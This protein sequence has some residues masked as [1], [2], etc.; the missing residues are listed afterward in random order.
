MQTHPPRSEGRPLV[1]WS[2]TFTNHFHPEVGQ[3]AVTV[4]EFLGY[5]VIVP[6]QTCCGRPLYDF[7]LLDSA[8]EHLEDVFATLADIKE[9]R[10]GAPIDGKERRQGVPVDG[11]ERRQGVPVDGKERRQGVPVDRVATDLPIV[12]L[13]PSCFS[14]FHDEARALTSD[15]PI[16]RMLAR[17]AVLFDT[18]IAAHLERGERRRPLVKCWRTCIVISVRSRASSRRRV[19]SPPPGSR[20]G[21]STP[22]A[23]A[24][25]ARSA[26]TGRTT[27]CR[28]TW[29]SAGCCRQCAT[30]RRKR[31]SWPADSAAGSRSSS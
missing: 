23:A 29:V 19:P 21:S 4:L 17:R 11:K 31:R 22:A 10:Q 12:V 18:F 6:P 25:P 16:A 28:T 14:V 27:A 9:P 7:G 30:R 2:D 20:L 24:W 13:E 5:H 3:A 8:R 1:L 26:T 15:R